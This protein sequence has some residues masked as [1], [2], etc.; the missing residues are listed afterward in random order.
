MP[1]RWKQRTAGFPDY[2]MI[3]LK[4]RSDL[5]AGLVALIVKDYM[6]YKRISIDEAKN[7]M[8]TLDVILVDVRVAQS[9]MESRIPMAFNISGVNA[10]EFIAITNK[11]KPLIVYCYHG[12]NSKWAADFFS[13]KGFTQVYSMDGGFEEWRL[14]Y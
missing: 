2:A 1:K 13:S 8:E 4:E 6:S 3:C 12:N 11:E 14:K 10:E 9:Y 7:M 5:V